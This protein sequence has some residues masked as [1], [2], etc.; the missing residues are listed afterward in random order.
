MDARATFHAAL[1]RPDAAPDADTGSA[2]RAEAII[3]YASK[4]AAAL[5]A[6]GLAWYLSQDIIA[7][8]TEPKPIGGMDIDKMPSHFQPWTPRFYPIALS[9]L[10]AWWRWPRK[11][12]V[13]GALSPLRGGFAMAQVGVFCIFASFA[14]AHVGG[15]ITAMPLV[16]GDD[17]LKVFFRALAGAASLTLFFSFFFAIMLFPASIGF[18]MLLAWASQAAARRFGPAGG[19]DA[20]RPPVTWAGAL[21]G[22]FIAILVGLG[23]FEMSVF[24]VT[25]WVERLMSVAIPCAVAGGA[26]AWRRM[27]WPAAV[28]AGEIIGLCYGYQP[29]M[30]YGLRIGHAIHAVPA[31]AATLAGYAIFKRV[32]ARRARAGT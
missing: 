21:A 3:V 30:D 27:P 19:H 28:L 7:Y 24:I 5:F 32:M 1:P 29:M 6:F 9:M 25:Y 18:G 26:L 12:V 31:I 22:G 17:Y 23:F 11:C 15:Y 16:L 13:A 20:G 2:A 14:C 8:A 10:F 4:A